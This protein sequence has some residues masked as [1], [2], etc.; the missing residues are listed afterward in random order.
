LLT[1]EHPEPRVVLSE[2]STPTSCDLCQ[3][4]LEPQEIER[5]CKAFIRLILADEA[6]THITSEQPTNTYPSA[7]RKMKNSRQ[8][9]NNFA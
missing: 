5:I 9:R 4:T 7:I 3:S 2:T 1:S 6:G 8:Q